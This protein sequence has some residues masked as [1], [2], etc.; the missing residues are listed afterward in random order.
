MMRKHS[1]LTAATAAV[2]LVNA[3]GQTSYALDVH[4][5]DYNGSSTPGTFSWASANI[6]SDDLVPDS[7][8]SVANISTLTTLST[9]T[10]I[11]LDASRTLAGLGFNNA[12]AQTGTGQLTITGGTP[13]TSRFTLLSESNGVPSDTTSAPAIYVAPSITAEAIQINVPITLGNTATAGHTA[14]IVNDATSTAKSI[15][16]NNA[17]TQY[18]DTTDPLNPVSSSWG[19]T[20]TRAAA[21]NASVYLEMKGSNASNWS[22]DTVIDTGLRLYNAL[23]PYGAGKGDVTITTNGT[24][25]SGW[26]SGSAVINGLNGAGAIIFASARDFTVGASGSNGAFTGAISSS[27]S[28]QVN[29]N[30]IGTGTQTLSN[31]TSAYRNTTILDGT[32]SVDSINATGGTGAS[33]LGRGDATANSLR[34]DGGKLQYTGAGNT[35]DRLMTIGLRGADLGCQRYRRT[36]FYQCRLVC[37]RGHISIHRGKQHDRRSNH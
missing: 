10:G 23:L 5:T 22:G 2:A 36:C 25:R 8:T 4:S 33:S 29:L 20:F 31:A 14:Y 34:I 16:F 18:V 24:L 15:V 9:G 28:N 19:V 11:T 3:F 13:S 35:T 12:L 30:K 37:Y 7:S 21:A 6:W 32:L 27:G 26:N 17:I 1:V